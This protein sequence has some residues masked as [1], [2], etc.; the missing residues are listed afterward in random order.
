M[1]CS[2][3]GAIIG[4]GDLFCCQCGNKIENIN[5]F[6]LGEKLFETTVFKNKGDKLFRDVKQQTTFILYENGI[7]YDNET[8]K[9]FQID[10]MSWSKSAP[11]FPEN[12]GVFITMYSLKDGRD[13]IFFVSNN[14]Y[15]EYAELCTK[16]FL[17]ICMRYLIEKALPRINDLNKSI[18]FSNDGVVINNVSW[19]FRSDRYEF[20][21]PA[22]KGK[23]SFASYM[24]DWFGEKIRIEFRLDNGKKE[25]FEALLCSVGAQFYPYVFE[26]LTNG[27][28]STMEEFLRYC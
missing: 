4:N 9:L 2:K 20:K 23:I 12:K 28:V 17:R 22:L 15:D 13:F 5:E 19:I 27:K 7:V 3:C 11:I 26:N 25:S 6:S 16:V 1:F 10:A 14:L 18:V 24:D 21:W 8:I